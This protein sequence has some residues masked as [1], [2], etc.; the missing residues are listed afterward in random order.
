MFR[1]FYENILYYL[2][3]SRLLKD[4]EASKLFTL[5]ET[6]LNQSKV[7]EE[8]QS[9]SDNDYFNQVYDNIVMG[10]TGAGTSCDNST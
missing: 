1:N 3:L 10:N 6:G 2:N 9:N 4:K 8:F 7:N 5:F